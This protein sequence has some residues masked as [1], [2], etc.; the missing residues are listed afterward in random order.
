MLVNKNN[1]SKLQMV[2]IISIAIA[3]F[4][5]C[6]E[7]AYLMRQLDV[8]EPQARVQDVKLTG[9]SLQKA[10]IL[11][12]IAIE[13]PNAVGVHLSTL[14]YDLQLDRASFLK[15]QKEDDLRIAARGNTSIQIPFSITYSEVYKAVKSFAD[16]DTIPYQLDLKIGVDVPVMGKLNIPVTKKGAIPNIKMPSISLKGIKLDKIG[17][18]GA[19]LHFMIDIKNPNALNFLV[20]NF[21]YSLDVNGKNWIKGLLDKPLEIKKKGKQTVTLPVSLNFL[22]MGS[23]VYQLLSGNQKLQY[24]L[25]GKADFNSDFALL[26]AFSLPFDKNGKIDLSK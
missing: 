23:A 12:D 22:E 3:L 16:L 5:G 11:F 14:E 19:D 25:R 13:N 1:Y 8:K 21:N 7:A 26:K 24:R 15:G 18:S 17:F 2:L 4:N 10:D 20:N 6:K 9:L